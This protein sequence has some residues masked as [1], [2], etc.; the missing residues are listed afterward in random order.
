MSPGT[1]F[2]ERDLPTIRFAL[3]TTSYKPMPCI[4]EGD[5]NGSD[6]SDNLNSALRA[7]RAF[8]VNKFIRTKITIAMT[9]A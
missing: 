6:N 2:S 7:L 5:T 8:V 4:F 1:A 3:V 9:A